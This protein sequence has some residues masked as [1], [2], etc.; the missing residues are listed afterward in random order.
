VSLWALVLDFKKAPLELRAKAL[1]KEKEFASQIS[2]GA[3]EKV[4]LSTCNRVELYAVSDSPP[5]VSLAKW[6]N[7]CGLSDVEIKLFQI[8]QGQD[9]LRHLFRVAAS[10]ESMVIGESQIGG[11]VKA[12]YEEAREAE[13]IGPLFHRCFQRAFKVA[14]RVR[15]QTEVGRLAVSIPSIGVKLAERVLGNLS[16][17]VVGII[18]LG[19]MGKLSAEH[20]GSVQ[21]KKI[22][23]HN[24]TF[25]VAEKLAHDLQ[26]ENI[27]AVATE[28]L[29]NLLS[30]ADVI[31][32]A[33]DGVILKQKELKELD[34]RRDPLFVLDLSV[35]PSLEP[36]SFENVF[37]YS[38]DDLQKIAKENTQLREQEMQKAESI[39]ESEATQCFERLHRAS[40]SKTL[41]HLSAKADRLTQGELDHLKSKLG[42]LSDSD[43][44]EIEKMAH[45]LSHKVLHDP[46]VE[47][48]SLLDS[49]EESETVITYFRNLF[50]L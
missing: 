35:P 15:S 37:F 38:I 2:E 22:L 6:Q 41:E 36:F 8:F 28:Q 5:S 20:F 44:A 46:I 7:I 40:V 29:S 9:A 10:M 19:E 16:Q 27:N 47:L 48:R 17:K 18:G 45:R 21:P 32:S 26:A 24:R 50:R 42:H 34:S 31:V 23:L 11:Q 4:F 14:K 49:S 1:R 13:T 33:V 3:I 12:A 30:E 39:I 43:W 25:S